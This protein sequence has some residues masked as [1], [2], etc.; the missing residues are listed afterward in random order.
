MLTGT[1]LKE[2]DVKTSRP[3]WSALIFETLSVIS[4]SSSLEDADT[5]KKVGPLSCLMGFSMCSSSHTNTD[6]LFW[7]KQ[8]MG[9]RCRPPHIH[10][11]GRLPHKNHLALCYGA[12][13]GAAGL[14]HPVVCGGDIS[15]HSA[16]IARSAEGRPASLCHRPPRHR[17]CCHQGWP[18]RLH[19]PHPD[20]AGPPST[21]GPIWIPPDLH[22]AAD[23]CSETVMPS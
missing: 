22:P 20:L 3:N 16:C 14:V 17:H 5:A 8:C 4:K 7:C 12:G 2:T 10:L 15:G 1:S 13:R 9:P 21:T 18:P 23:T 6:L 11:H 19:Q